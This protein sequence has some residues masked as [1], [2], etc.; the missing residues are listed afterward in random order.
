MF[1]GRAMRAALN[2]G[3]M[4]PVAGV[5]ST[6]WLPSE[7]IS[8][9]LK[10]IEVTEH[11]APLG[12]ELGTAATLIQF[13]AQDERKERTEHMAADGGVRGMIDRPRAHQRFGRAEQVFHLQ[14]V[15]I[16]QHGIVKLMA[17]RPGTGERAA[18][19]LFSG[20][21]SGASLL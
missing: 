11:I 3:P 1:A 20:H 6:I 7:L 14:Q 12:P 21:H 10:A 8:T 19:D 2:N 15:A 13:L 4:T 16:A 18:A 17:C 5:R 9:L